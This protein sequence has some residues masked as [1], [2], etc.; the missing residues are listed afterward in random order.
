MIRP[1]TFSAAWTTAMVLLGSLVVAYHAYRIP[2]R[3]L[4]RELALLPTT[5]GA[6]HGE[7]IPPD[8]TPLALA[9]TDA[10]L[11]RVYRDP[12]GAALTLYVGYFEAQEQGRELIGVGSTKRHR[13]ASE[14]AVTVPGDRTYQISRTVLPDHPRRPTVFFWYDLNGRIVAT[15]YGSKVTTLVDGL[16]RLRTNGAL[17]AISPATPDDGNPAAVDQVSGQVAGFVALLMPVLRAYLSPG[18]T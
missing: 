13:L 10:Q 14:V 12:S 4:D 8:D 3:P 7:D 11:A 2:P 16:T 17:V 9:H 15:R 1:G 6:W 18:T 5:L